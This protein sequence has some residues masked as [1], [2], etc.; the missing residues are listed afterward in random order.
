MSQQNRPYAGGSV[1]QNYE[2]YLV[3]LL[4]L[5]YAVDLASRLDVPAGAAVLETACGSGAVTRHLQARIPSDARLTASDLAPAMLEQARQVVSDVSNV[6]FR[7]A[8]ATD[9][10]FADNA[11]DAVICQFGLMLFPD[12]AQGMREAA[13]VLKPG[14]QYV[15]NVWDKLEN[16][17]F[18]QAVHETMAQIFPDDPPRF[19]EVPCSYHD[20][21]AMVRALQAAGFGTVDITVQPR[22]SKATDPRQVAMGL[23]AGSPLANQIAERGSPSLEEATAA[24]ADALAKRFGS[25]P[26]S[27]PMQAFQVTA[28]LP[29]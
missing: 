21:T 26:I 28:H 17:G 9:L 4:F 18:S 19:L 16:N 24:V 13:R 1:P 6:D 23:V 8:D 5:D 12:K 14:G 25:G 2:R 11:F 22:Q 15:F 10:P 27:A 3:P 7:E 29:A 20:L